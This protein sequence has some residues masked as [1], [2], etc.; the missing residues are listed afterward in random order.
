M[1]GLTSDQRVVQGQLTPTLLEKDDITVSVQAMEY[2]NKLGKIELLS[3]VPNSEDTFPATIGNMIY[4]FDIWGDMRN[5]HPL[6]EDVKHIKSVSFNHTRHF[7]Y[8]QR[9][10]RNGCSG[11]AEHDSTDWFATPDCQSA[12]E[13]GLPA[14]PVCGRSLSFRQ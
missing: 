11:D 1:V 2:I 9:S 12:P 4:Q 13:T 5:V 8:R 3:K 10:V 14:G 6:T 7:S